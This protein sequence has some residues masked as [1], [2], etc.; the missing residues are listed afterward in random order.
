MKAFKSLS[1]GILALA[2]AVVS[3]LSGINFIAYGVVICVILAT[4]FCV[5][6]KLDQKYYPHL[7][8]LLGAS[9]LLQTTLKS[10]GLIG[11]DLHME[12]YFYQLALNGWDITIP[13]SY[14]TALGT[15]MIAPFLTNAFGFSGYIIYKLIFPALFAIA[16]MLL[17]YVYKKEFGKQ[18][19]FIGCILFITL[20]TYLLEMIG[21]PRQMLGELMLACCMILIVVSPY[22]HTVLLLI[23]C[24]SLGVMFHYIM[25]PAIVLY[26]SGCAFVIMWFKRRKFAVRYI[27]ATVIIITGLGYWYYANVSG[28]TVLNDFNIVGTKTVQRT[29]ES[30][31]NPDDVEIPYVYEKIVDNQGIAI[32]PVE[33]EKASYFSAQE[34]AIRAALGLD[35]AAASFTGKL[36][37]IF[38]FA[39][40][41]CLILGGIHLLANRK[42]YS[43]EYLGFTVTAIG[44]IGACILL[45]R[46]SNMINATRFYHLALFLVSPLFIMGGL[47]IF[48]NLKNMVIILIIPYILFTTG[49]VF[50]FTKDTDI[51]RINIPYS[52]ALS[53][54]RVGITGEFTQNDI[55]VRDY[56]IE[57]KLEPIFMDI[58]GM[59]LFSEKKDYTTYQYT[60]V[61]DTTKMTSGWGL[62]V[63]HTSELPK[64]YIFIT[65]QNNQSETMIFKPN[66][67]KQR[68]SATGMREAVAFSELGI[69]IK[70]IVYQ[71]GD[72]MII[73]IGE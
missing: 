51:G 65:E 12:Y 69:E 68:E 71:S 14:N 47:Y 54:D 42:R 41:I 19:A 13:H 36:F 39:M 56:A 72:S 3:A 45:P 1:I 58:N 73:K 48:R 32:K 6:N 34:P 20:P 49:A 7:I 57:N 66:W 17:Y 63:E 55:K 50:E 26:L 24:A 53:N 37:R 44:L 23:V 46:F 27:V 15:T 11:T 18:I 9:L 38:Q 60:I 5:W 4:L 16:P 8:Y 67:F 25:L 62:L 61:I 2:F 40:E 28:G 31:G 29:I 52:I 21:L 59:L 70:N 35:F 43:P 30:M 10:F 22:K 33:T 64:G